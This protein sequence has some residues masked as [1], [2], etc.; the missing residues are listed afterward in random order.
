MKSY[1][2]LTEFG[3]K[4]HFRLPF[5]D[6]A[7]ELPALLESFLKIFF[8]GAIATFTDEKCKRKVKT[9]LDCCFK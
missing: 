6:E 2:F 3:K 8:G 4:I 7:D 1:H 5:F 9:Q